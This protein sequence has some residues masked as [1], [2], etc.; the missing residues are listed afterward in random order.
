MP[1]VEG[2]GRWP[3]GEEWLWE[4][5][6]RVY[7]PLLETL[8]D[9]PVT[10]ALSPVL[11]D[12]LETLSGA[13]GRRFQRFLLNVRAPLHCEALDRL[14]RD[15]DATARAEV[16]RASADYLRAQDAFTKLDGNVLGAFRAL[17]GGDG[18]ELW[19]SSATHAILPLL[20]SEPAL[21]LQLSTGIE[22]HRERFG[23]WS[24]GFWLPEC[25]Y[26][27]RLEHALAEHGVRAFCIDQA[28]A[29]DPASLDALE[30]ILTAGGPVALPIDPQASRLLWRS[31]W[32]YPAAAPYRSYEKATPE[33]IHFW[34]NDGSRYDHAAAVALAKQHARDFI[35]RVR[36]RLQRY[37]SERG[38][39]GLL[40]V[41]IDAEVFG[42]WWYEGQTWLR[43]TIALAQSGAVRL[44]GVSGALAACEPVKRPLRRSS[45]GT[46]G[47]LSSWDS[48]RSAELTRVARSA[49]LSFAAASRSPGIEHAALSRAARELLALQA[50][51]WSY[52]H[53]HELAGAY[54]RERVMAHAATLAGALRGAR[55]G[56]LAPDPCLRNLAPGLDL[57][58]LDGSA[59]EPVRLAPHRRAHP[60]SLPR[61][62]AAR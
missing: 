9:A 6:A 35:A 59:P 36:A 44:S 16:E 11:C 46:A 2:F 28:H 40:C 23:P 37:E 55:T 60:A 27:P 26:V 19:T 53:T 39:P 47:D 7:L 25:A 42:H 61:T 21:R 51:D 62:V 17:A 1:Y 15:R 24:G 4:A 48:P 10:L 3:F 13:A 8:R 45:W 14:A 34:C 50:S 41:A 29:V 32:R 30:P 54:P 22:S 57:C 31:P 58:A 38:R 43:E 52:L 33:A 49:E 20:A 18:P 12:Q 56:A 5:L